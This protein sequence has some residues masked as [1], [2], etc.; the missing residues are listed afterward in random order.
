[1]SESHT[2]ELKAKNFASADNSRRDGCYTT[3]HCAGDANPL[4]TGKQN[5][6]VNAAVQGTALGV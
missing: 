1:M 2:Q 4:E 3:K 6:I 5:L